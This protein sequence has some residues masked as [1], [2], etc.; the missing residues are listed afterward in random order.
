M[1]AISAIEVLTARKPSQAKKN[2]QIRPAVPPF[3]RPI[4]DVPRAVSQLHMRIIEKPKIDTKRKFRCRT[5]QYCC[6]E[7]I[8][9]KRTFNS[10]GLPIRYM[11]FRSSI[12]PVSPARELTSLSSSTSRNTPSSFTV[13]VD[14]SM[15]GKK[16]MRSSGGSS[17]FSSC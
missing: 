1:E 17:N 13:I 7:C 12:E 16:M 3:R 11:S 5:H 10:C 15:F 14:L 8:L 2:I 9:Q 6:L 4:V